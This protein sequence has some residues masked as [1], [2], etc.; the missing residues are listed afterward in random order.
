MSSADRDPASPA[1]LFSFAHPDDES[2]SGAGTAMKYGAEGV[3]TVLVTATRGERGK[4][5]DPPICTTEELSALR[6]FFALYRATADDPPLIQAVVSVAEALLKIGGSDGRAIV[7]R[8][9]KDP[10]TQPDVARALGAL[11]PG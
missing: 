2:F 10:M 7:Q 1:I 3:R 9:A 11:A 8:A 4:R 6:T 5:G